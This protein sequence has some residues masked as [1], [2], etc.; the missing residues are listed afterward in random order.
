MLV[1]HLIQQFADVNLFCVFIQGIIHFFRAHAA[2]L[3]VVQAR[4]RSNELANIVLFQVLVYTVV[5]GNVPQLRITFATTA[6]V[7]IHTMQHFVSK[8]ELNFFWAQHFD[9]ASVVIEIA[10]ICGCSGAP[11]VSIDQ[12]ETGGQVAK[13]TG[14]EQETHTSSDQ[15][16][17]NFAVYFG[18]SSTQQVFELVGFFFVGSGC[19]HVGP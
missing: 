3:F 11:F 13:E 18:I 6:K 2:V 16:L 17:A 14:T 4:N 9:E 1:Q 10:A 15:L 7:V 19:S 8:Q 12:L 5:I